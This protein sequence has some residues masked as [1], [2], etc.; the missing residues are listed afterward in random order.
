MLEKFILKIIW[1]LSVS[2]C[3]PILCLINPNYLFMPSQ[4]I[5]SQLQQRQIIITQISPKVVQEKE[6]YFTFLDIV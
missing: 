3:S 1:F 4:V 6:T 2:N 5:S